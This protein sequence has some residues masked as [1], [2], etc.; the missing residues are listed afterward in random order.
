MRCFVT[1]ATGF[2]GSATT[3]ELVARG[4]TVVG[5]TSDPAKVDALV[6]AGVEPVVGDLRRPDAWLDH[7]RGAE[8]IVHLASL[9]IPARPGTR[10]VK[11]LLQVQ[12]LVVERLLDAASGRCTA[13]VYASAA[14]VYRPSP[15]PSTE[16][17]PIDPCRIGQPFAAG[18]RRVLRAAAERGIPG[19]V[20]R[21]AGVYGFG[22]V[23]GRFWAQPMAAGKRTGIPG[24]GRQLWSFVHIDDCARAFVHAVENP[25]P[26][27]VFNVADDEPVPLGVMIHAFADAL[28]APRPRS[29]PA[30]LFTALAG[31]VVGELLLGDKAISN[32]K[33]REQLGVELR[34]PTY[35]DGIADLARAQEARA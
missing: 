25:M 18:E 34:Y 19:V 10:Y 6:A 26:G 5:L 32:R 20:L 15:T 8:A 17:T 21:S 3:R 12:E 22:G 4:H 31:T 27:E 24:S 13:F 2:I 30:P 7:V 29:L 35:E 9:P 33:M 1:G 23:F 16:Q 11:D 14:S 28:R